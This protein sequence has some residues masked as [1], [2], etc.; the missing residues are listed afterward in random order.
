MV[1]SLGEALPVLRRGRMDIGLFP[2]VLSPYALRGRPPLPVAIGVGAGRL[3]ANAK[4]AAGSS[5]IEGETSK[6]GQLSEGDL[7]EKSEPQREPRVRAVG[8]A[9]TRGRA[10]A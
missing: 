6:P 9:Y 3:A 2:R 4:A 8:S 5:A 10:E 7:E 1:R